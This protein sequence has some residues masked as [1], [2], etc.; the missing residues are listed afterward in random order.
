M[1]TTEPNNK[2]YSAAELIEEKGP[3]IARSVAAHAHHTPSA[4]KRA[5]E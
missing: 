2:R 3:A 1:T 4:R 5:I